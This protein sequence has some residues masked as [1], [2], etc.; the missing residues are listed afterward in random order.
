ML[1]TTRQLADY[2]MNYQRISV[3]AAQLHEEYWRLVENMFR[4]QAARLFQ[5]AYRKKKQKTFTGEALKMVKDESHPMRFLKEPWGNKF[6][7]YA[8]LIKK[9]LWL[10]MDFGDS[11]F[12]RNIYKALR[13][14]KITKNEMA[15]A[16]LLKQAR[17]ELTTQVK[18][19]RFTEKQPYDP[20]SIEFLTPEN[21]EKFYQ[22]VQAL[23]EN[24]R[25]YF[26]INFSRQ[27]EILFLYDGIMDG[28]QLTREPFLI[29][30]KKYILKR[31][32]PSGERD[33]L[34]SSFIN[35]SAKEKDIQEA[36][37]NDLLNFIKERERSYSQYLAYQRY[38][39]NSFSVDSSFFQSTKATQDAALFTSLIRPRSQIPSFAISPD[40]DENNSDSPLLCMIL[41]TM[42]VLN[43]LSEHTYSKKDATVPFFTAGQVST[44]LIR[45][46]D[47]TPQKFN[48]PAQSRPVELTHPDLVRSPK[49]HDLAVHDF[50]LSWH[51]LLHIWISS[52]II[53]KDIVRY[54]R[55]VLTAEKKFD[56]SKTIW[57]LTDMD[58][59][60]IFE[61][62]KAQKNGEQIA[63]IVWGFQFIFY[64]IDLVGQNDFWK[65]LDKHDT[66]LLM[67]I[68]MIVNRE[69][70]KNFL[71]GK[72]PE[73]MFKL[74]SPNVWQTYSIN[75]D[76]GFLGFFTKYDFCPFQQIFVDM[77][78]IIDEK[79]HHSTM[80]YI[81]Y[82]RL[83]N[84]A[85]ALSLLQEANAFGLEKIFSWTVNHGLQIKRNKKI[86]EN[87]N[88]EL[89]HS[90]LW[91]EVSYMKYI[92]TLLLQRKS[93]VLFPPPKVQIQSTIADTDIKMEDVDEKTEHV[94]KKQK[95]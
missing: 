27:R 95:T 61:E 4:E 44:R 18:Q 63:A 78:K 34:L 85:K 69:S 43:K 6:I 22:S 5:R 32:V 19:H 62:R 79:S 31:T 58:F 88:E 72:Y 54:L 13:K 1:T 40:Y 74:D 75:V 89:I 68:D 52:S 16:L 8:D 14:G 93:L 55:Q 2:S 80:F 59:V 11:E 86:V 90:E 56:M 60:W 39:G 45:Y 15:T 48:Q 7:E 64:L 37:K 35:L 83:R 28:A 20:A 70:W 3:Y 94:S 82:Y 25:C 47:E 67:I 49:P 26:S 24:E 66:N 46:L 41:P 33:K 12:D 65:K 21:L 73:E 30:L 84:N 87:L 9:G 29:A 91:I 92:T 36:A 38:P 42:T 10:Q 77:K 17:T 71:G 23:P 57:Q 50:L 53:H 81:L 76:E 51:D